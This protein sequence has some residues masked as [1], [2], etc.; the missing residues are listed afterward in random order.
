MA[1][2]ALS[3]SCGKHGSRVAAVVCCHH[4][5]NAGRPAGF[6]ENS[7]DPSDLQAWCDTCEQV[8]LAQ[9]GKTEEFRKFNNMTIVC[10]LCYIALKSHHSLR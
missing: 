7:E 6:V 1:D 3:I 9:G 10:D 4:L 8:Y 5:A 2:A